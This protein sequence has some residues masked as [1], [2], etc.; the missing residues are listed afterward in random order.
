[1][2]YGH[3]ELAATMSS[4]SPEHE[5]ASPYPRHS[6]GGATTSVSARTPAFSLPPFSNG[7]TSRSPTRPPPFSLLALQGGEGG[8]RVPREEDVFFA[9]DAGAQDSHDGGGGEAGWNGAVQQWQKQH[10]H[11]QQHA[12]LRSSPSPPTP[13]AATHRAAAHSDSDGTTGTRQLW[14]AIPG[15]E[16]LFAVVAGES[17][18]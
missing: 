9:E 17:H 12:A 13:P 11:Q 2:T 6:R 7:S 4:P 14:K 16:P 3:I 15:I 5:D 18:Y 1:V 10:R 8:A